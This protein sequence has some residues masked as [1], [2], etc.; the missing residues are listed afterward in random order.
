[1]SPIHETGVPGDAERKSLPEQMILTLVKNWAVYVIAPTSPYGEVKLKTIALF[2]EGLRTFDLV[3]L[4]N[5]VKSGLGGR[6]RKR[7]GLSFE[8]A[9]VEKYP[10]VRR[11]L[12]QL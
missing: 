8:F 9:D 5:T 6:A 10:V 1:M 7:D 3:S 12:R 2:V 4:I 11:M